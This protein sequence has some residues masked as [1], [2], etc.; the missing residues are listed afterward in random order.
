MKYEYWFAEITSLSDRK[1]YMLRKQMGS[2]E[3]IFYI[4]ETKLKEMGFLNEKDIHT[5][6]QAQKA[7]KLDEKAAKIVEMAIHFVPYFAEEFPGRL[8]NIPDPPYALYVKGKLPHEEKKAV[9]IVGARRST[10][11]GEK[12][13][14]EFGEKLA[15]YGISVIS[16]MAR[17]IDGTAQRGALMGKGKTYA[18][19]GCGVDICYPREHIGLYADILENGG[20]IL[21]EFPPGTPPAPQNFP[22]RNRI[23]SGLS[24]LVLVMEARSKSGSLITADLA[25]EQG[26]DV[27]AL[28]GPV[29]S[30]LS[31]GCNELIRQG[32]G[33]LLSPEMVLEVLNIDCL[34]GSEKITKNKKVLES[35]EN[36]VY[37]RLGL[38]PKNLSQ[39]TEE[40]MLPANEVLERLVSLELKGYIREVSKNYYIKMK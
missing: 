29:N 11:Y 7:G 39:L 9:A 27:Y 18:V 28:P 32:A 5:I 15:E 24:D 36:M 14:L 37:S 33:I 25:L 8:R 19:L 6:M 20:G 13:A 23:I 38:Y 35:G 40:T 10:P 3:R 26:R 34:E 31:Q 12:Y 1:K 21:S 2:G 17:G 30:S 16:G 22:R 4:E